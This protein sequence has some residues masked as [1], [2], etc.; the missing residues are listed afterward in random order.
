RK[1]ELINLID[2]PVD[3]VQIES[4]NVKPTDTFARE[5]GARFGN[6][7]SRDNPY[8]SGKLEPNEATPNSQVE[9]NA[10]HAT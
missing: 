2:P 9:S 8:F 6:S 3:H 5:Q 4:R 7:G 1:R 10:T